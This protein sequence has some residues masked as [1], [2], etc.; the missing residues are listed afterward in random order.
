MKIHLFPENTYCY[1]ANLHCHT[2]FSDGYK[3]PEQIKKVYKD[4]GYSVLAI[5]DHELFI[6]HDELNDIDFLCLHGF[7]M[8][9]GEAVKKPFKLKKY[10][11]IGLIALSPDL[12]TQPCYHREKYVYP[13]RTH[14][15]SLVRFDER[16]PD[17]VRE[18]SPNGI[19]AIMQ[20]AA[21][22]GFFVI[23]NHP[24]WG[25]Q[26]YEE[27]TN[28]HGMQAV[29]IFNGGC[30]TN[31]YA[32]F[33][34][35]VYDDLLRKGRR[36]FCIGADDNHNAYASD[37]PLND[38]GIAFTMIFSEKLEY[39]SITNALMH[40][41]FYASQGPEIFCLWLEDQKI[42]IKC[43][44][45]ASICCNYGV[46]RAEIV[47]NQKAAVFT[48]EPD[49]FYFRIT[50]TDHKGKKACTNGYFTEDIFKK[51]I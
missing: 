7:E 30:L 13:D 31:G 26:T 32:D 45:A 37:H 43:T 40:G 47:Y 6:P 42:Y 1:K 16:L 48:L 19:T 4:L 49:D 51:E 46:R 39:T 35:K 44:E 36:L 18:L 5:T 22:K 50:V 34:A 25:M 21:E 17:Y 38:S 10:C 12:L 33:D 11:H 20:T 14:F 3:T 8:D 9:V 41:H 2:T 27:Y 15:R 29:E 24:T 23:Y 28:Y